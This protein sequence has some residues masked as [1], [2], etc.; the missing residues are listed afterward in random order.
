M[1]FDAFVIAIIALSAGAVFGA[2]NSV[3]G[4]LKSNEPFNTRQFAITTITGIIAG[5]ALVFTNISGII[6]AETNF[7]LL[8]QIAGL[9][10]AIFGINFLRTVG[11]ELI[12]QRAA[13]QSETL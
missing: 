12:A 11:S 7:D 10:F 8:Y 3:L 4:W 1:A 2:A 6:T 5:L 9:A 13:E